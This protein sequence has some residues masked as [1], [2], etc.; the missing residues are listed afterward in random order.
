MVMMGVMPCDFG[1]EMKADVFIS[2]S[3][4]NIELADTIVD[5]LEGNGISCWY[6]PRNIG[7]GQEWVSAIDDAIGGCKVFLLLYTA[8]SNASK[9]VANEVALAFNAG[10]MI[11]PYRAADAPM[12]SEIKYYL[13]RVHW[14][15]VTTIPREEGLELLRRRTREML[16]E[17][18]PANVQTSSQQP[19]NAQT[20]RM[21]QASMMLS[22]HRPKRKP[23]VAA[24]IAFVCIA[25][26]PL[27]VLFIMA[28]IFLKTFQNYGTKVQYRTGLV[29]WLDG[30]LPEA[31]V[32][33]EKVAKKGD[34]RAKLALGAVKVQKLIEDAKSNMSPFD[35][36]MKQS[37][38]IDIGEE[39]VRAGCVEGNYLLGACAAEGFGGAR[40]KEKAIAYFEKVIEGNE[41]A[42]RFRSYGYLC[43]LYGSSQG[44]LSADAERVT[45]YGT[46]AEKLL[47]EH[48][49]TSYEATKRGDG[50]ISVAYQETCE[51]IGDAYRGLG[52]P[53]EAFAWYERAADAGVA[54]AMNQLGLAYLRGDGVEEDQEL[55]KEWFQKA[56]DA[57]DS[58]AVK[59]LE[60]VQ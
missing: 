13:T 43:L 3:S 24:K 8:E 53:K 17:T 6:A 49:W 55:A 14:M 16:D 52:M 45:Y 58:N 31:E 18:R 25:A 44:E 5:K 51:K 1:G 20:D 10:K 19:A 33:F 7:P 47:K 29:Q 59:N 35:V 9:Q 38:I 50:E 40:E 22:R 11:L 4:K 57:G 15:D 39:L 54:S 37:E 48:G 36:L 34:A 21:L 27:L 56:A 60:Y 41:L 32:S 2:Y 42:W 26:I 23:S 12:S 28:S 30:E 46:L